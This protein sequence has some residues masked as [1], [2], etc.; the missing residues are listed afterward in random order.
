MTAFR[1]H[2]E[3]VL[4]WRGLQLASEEAKLRGLIE[5]QSLLESRLD[6]IQKTLSEM[7]L[8]FT[9]LDKLQGS[10]LNQMAAYRMR[11]TAERDRVRGLCREK[12]RA[13]GEQVEVHRRAK[14]RH[15]LLEELRSRRHREWQ[16]LLSRELEQL[17]QES[18]LARWTT[19]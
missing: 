4:H 5:E 16:A 18:Y 9:A 8:L 3:R 13:V 2:L 15:R 1:F 17:A 19:V 11:L 12:K 14:Q 10:D 6:G 7:P